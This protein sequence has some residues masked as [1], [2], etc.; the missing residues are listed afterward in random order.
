MHTWATV[1]DAAGVRD[2]RLRADFTHRRGTVARYRPHAYLAVRLLLPARLVAPVIAL[3]AFMHHTDTLLDTGPAAGRD[4]VWKRWEEDVRSALAAGHSR[5]PVLRPVLHTMAAHPALHGHIEDFLAAAP[6]DLHFTGFA[7]EADY[8]EY[9]GSY[10]LPAFMLIAGLL[11]PDGADT[12]AYRAACRLYI[13][14][15]Q[16]LD[17]VNDLAED[18][19]DGRL[20][21]P[22]ETLREHGVTRAGLAAGQDTPGTRAMLDELLTRARRSLAESGSLASLAVADARPLVR[23]MTALESLTADAARASGCGVLH[24]SARPSLPGALGVLAREYRGALRLRA[25]SGRRRG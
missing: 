23:A 7:T 14:G 21:I 3:T 16:R 9:V 24:R 11:A 6:T 22:Q 4:E 13:D 5:H 18:L 12:A 20:T 2:E 1:L 25:A 19:R 17:F 10:S 8:Q 15:S